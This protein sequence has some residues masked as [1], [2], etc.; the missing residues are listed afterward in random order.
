MAMNQTCYALATKMRVPFALH[1]QLRHRMDH[2]VHAAHGS[3]FDTITTSTF[4]GALFVLPPAHVLA[5]FER[6]VSPLI[7]RILVA[8]EQ[9]VIFAL[10]RDTLL[11]K[12]VSGELL[13]KRAERIVADLE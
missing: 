13:L 7:S 1:L 9:S 8:S 10:L 3:V 6:L 2:L 12:L 11:P 5:A 4:N